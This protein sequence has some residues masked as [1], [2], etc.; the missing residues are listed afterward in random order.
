MLMHTCP[1]C[2]KLIP[3]G[4]A[5]CP[6]CTDKSPSKQAAQR[7]NRKRDRKYLNFY[8]SKKWLDLSHA[9]MVDVRYRCEDCGAIAV[10][11]HHDPP[12]QTG[13]G[14]DGRYEWLHLFALCTRCHNK[15]HHRFL[16]SKTA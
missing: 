4:Q 12:I 7:Y 14:W 8:K 16:V 6:G 13:E 2:G 3:Y 1:K 11:V 9:K 5:R 15:R 10:E